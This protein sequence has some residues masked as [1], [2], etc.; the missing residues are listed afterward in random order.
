MRRWGIAA[1]C[2]LLALWSCASAEELPQAVQ[3]L[4]RKGGLI[5]GTLEDVLR[6]NCADGGQYCF[7][8]SENGHW[9]TGYVCRGENQE[10]WANDMSVTPLEDHYG[11]LHFEAHDRENL[12]PDGKPW[13]NAEGF[14]VVS[15]V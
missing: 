7:V 15:A 14:D 6:V 12:R 10:A 3:S 8:L 1:L 5:G 11:S 9:L 4:I 2:L 13:E